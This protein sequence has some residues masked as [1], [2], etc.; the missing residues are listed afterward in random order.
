MKKRRL[1]QSLRAADQ[2]KLDSLT[3]FGSAGPSL[4]TKETIWAGS[5][6][7]ASDLSVSTGEGTQTVLRTENCT[8]P[9]PEL[10]MKDCLFDSPVTMAKADKHKW[11]VRP[12]GIST[13]DSM[14]S[15]SEKLKG[16]N[17]L[18][19]EQRGAENMDD[20]PK[21]G[22]PPGTVVELFDYTQNGDKYVSTSI[23]I[24]CATEDMKTLFIGPTNTMTQQ[25]VEAY[26]R[27]VTKDKTEI[28]QRK[29][30]A[31]A[32]I[33]T[34]SASSMWGL[35]REVEQA[36]KD[37]TFHM[38]VVVGLSLLLAEMDPH[39]LYQTLSDRVKQTYVL[40][41]KP[42]VINT[43][44]WSVT[45]LLRRLGLSLKALGATGSTVLVCSTPVDAEFQGSRRSYH[46]PFVFRYPGSKN[47]N[48]DAEGFLCSHV[49]DPASTS[50]GTTCSCG[51]VRAAFLGLFKDVFDISLD[52]TAHHPK[53]THLSE[54]LYVCALR[55]ESNLI[56]GPASKPTSCTFPALL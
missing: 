45:T 34:A 26:L 41:H 19:L 6:S 55:L 25:A 28:I 2:V 23:A 7:T 52:L 4:V 30:K 24:A 17:H 29:G 48:A 46:K 16:I 3:K 49:M 40:G 36:A 42:V 43:G 33:Y 47:N 39:L 21:L 5:A 44:D 51:I 11:S 31:H 50:I 20:E 12:T 32:N 10:R 8:F 13:L 18:S 14:I 15:Y 1:E 38:V 9:K 35:I 22:L 53:G 56:S 54:G 27:E 37:G